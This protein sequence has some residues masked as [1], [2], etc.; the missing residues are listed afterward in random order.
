MTPT[1][2]SSSKSWPESVEARNAAIAD[3]G[4]WRT[5]RTLDGGGPTFD[6]DDGRTIVSF[7]SNDY[8]G[9]TQHPLVRAGA[10][11]ALER[12]GTGSGSARLIVGGRPVH[13]ELE[14][15]LASWKDAEAALLFPTGFAANLGVLTTFATDGVLVVS[16][17]LNH[18]SIIDGCRLSRGRVEIARHG[19]VDHVDALLARA[20]RPRDRRDRHR[21]L[22]GRRRCAARRT[23]GDVRPAGRLAHARRGPRRARSAA[24][25]RRERRGHRPAGRHAVEDAWI[26][27][28]LRRR[29]AS[30]RRPRRQCG[31][32]VHLHHRADTG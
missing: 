26:P 24:T 5:I 11:D 29:T 6:L 27:G 31:A 15:E 32:A 1:P 16:D 18:A 22:D 17:E 3:T 30:I 23:R 4:R 9:L 2:K 19:D 13:R 12:F 14:A 25:G 28:R 20:R 8:L 21:F 7:A 10:A